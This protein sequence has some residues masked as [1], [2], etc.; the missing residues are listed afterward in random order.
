MEEINEKYEY[1]PEM[2]RNLQLKNLEIF[3]VLKKFCEDNKLTIY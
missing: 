2:L 3:K 1:S